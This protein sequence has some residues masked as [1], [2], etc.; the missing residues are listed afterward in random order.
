MVDGAIRGQIPV[1]LWLL[2]V[3]ASVHRFYRRGVAVRERL[4]GYEGNK[5]TPEETTALKMGLIGQAFLTGGAW[6]LL[7]LILDWIF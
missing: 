5:P 3:G 2:F 1:A 4:I 7:F 6:L